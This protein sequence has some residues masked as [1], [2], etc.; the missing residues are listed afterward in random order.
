M[1]EAR[2]GKAPGLGREGRG[3]GL[4]PTKVGF[5]FLGLAVLI[6]VA[7]INTGN[8]GLFLVT[9]LML[10]SLLGAHLLGVHNLRGLTFSASQSGGAGL[11]D[12]IFAGRPFELG[13]R[14][15]SRGRL[16]RFQLA[17]RLDVPGLEGARRRPRSPAAFVARLPPG[18]EQELRLEAIARRRGRYLLREVKVSSLFPVGFFDKGRRFSAD[19]EWLVF[20]EIFP[21][22]EHRP[23]VLSGHGAEP[24]AR[25]GHGY[26]LLG[27]RPYHAG[28]DPRAIHWKQSA[29]QGQLISQQRQH[30]ELRRLELVFDNATGELD[31]TGRQ[32]FEQ[33]VS[34]AATTALDFLD[35]GCEVAL[36]TREERLPFGSGRR[37]RL[38]LLEILAL[39]EPRGLEKMPLAGDAA[40]G[41]EAAGS[42]RLHLGLAPAPGAEAA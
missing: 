20:P 19:L 37:H 21:R 39:V 22:G 15:K 4:Q 36:L 26:E 11:P 12:E 23:P 41:G 28:D 29:R 35:Q 18:E 31:E 5:Y 7:A 2:S 33:L 10:A 40:G 6:S 34:E 25:P 3:A 13:L 38:R 27:L 32:N 24:A 9:A 1:S 42:S 17:L 14:L 8:N 16:P 30:E